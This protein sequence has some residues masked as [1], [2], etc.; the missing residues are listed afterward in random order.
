MGQNRGRE[1]LMEQRTS[2]ENTK[3]G[4]ERN[5][6]K[7]AY[8]TEKLT[9]WGP[10]GPVKEEYKTVCRDWLKQTVLSLLTLSYAYGF[11]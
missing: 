11:E 10:E 2:L 9:G 7:S 8:R 1:V 3:N 4:R 5:K 6:K